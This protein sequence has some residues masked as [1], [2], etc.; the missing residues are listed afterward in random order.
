MKPKQRIVRKA[1]VPLAG[2][3]SR[4]GPVC[5]AVPKAMFPLVDSRGRLRPVV[6]HACMEA[7]AAGVERVALVVSAQ[8]VD[9][10]HRY[11]T[12]AGQA[13][14]A[15]L[16]VNVDFI[17]QPSPRGLGDAVMQVENFTA[18]EPFLLLLG[19]HVWVA[20]DRSRP[21][22]AQ[23]VEA[24]AEHRGAAMVGMQVVGSDR[25]S[26]VGVARGHLVA[27][28]VFRCSALVEKPDLAAARERLVSPELDEDRFLAHG[29]IYVFTP[30]IFDCLRELSRAYRSAGEEVQ[31]TDA[32]GI[33]LR[34]HPDDYHLVRIAGRCFD[35]GIPSGYAE[36]FEAIR[37]APCHA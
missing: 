1:V 23:V 10:F 11:F 8:Q 9:L 32:Q 19:D 18:G 24:Y 16:P 22:A 3:G 36:A 26:D 34:R 2:L 7:S 25:L 30:E 29:G 35:A 28:N 20:E 14:A 33:L 31:L 13:A 27:G 5:K 6:H 12:A 15:E 17:T 37:Q 4:M 21:C